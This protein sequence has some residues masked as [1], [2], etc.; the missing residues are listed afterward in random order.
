MAWVGCRCRSHAPRHVMAQQTAFAFVQKMWDLRRLGYKRSR[1][2]DP[3]VGGVTGVARLLH[4]S[5][6]RL[7]TVGTPVCQALTSM[8][9][10]T[11]QVCMSACQGQWMLKA[12]SVLVF[13]KRSDLMNRFSQLVQFLR[14]T[15]DIDT[16]PSGKAHGVN[17]YRAVGIDASDETIQVAGMAD[18]DATTIA[19]H[20]T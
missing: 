14:V 11:V 6:W 13:D 2:F 18:A 3:S 16:H 10:G 4:M 17:M 1:R 5:L 9:S 8:T 15:R 12:I 19:G 20:L 7:V